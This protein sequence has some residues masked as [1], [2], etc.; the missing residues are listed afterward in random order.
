M[1]PQPGDPV[2]HPARPPRGTFGATRGPARCVPPIAH[3]LA[4]GAS[5]APCGNVAPPVTG[6]TLGCMLRRPPEEDWAHRQARVRLSKATWANIAT[7][8]GHHAMPRSA[9]MYP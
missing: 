8:Y 4:L 6:G 2:R 3:D 5:T 1:M 7:R 9:S